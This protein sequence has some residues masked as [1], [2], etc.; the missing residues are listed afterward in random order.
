MHVSIVK[1]QHNSS[2]TAFVFGHLFIHSIYLAT[3][4]YSARLPITGKK[5]R[6]QPT[7]TV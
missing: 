2:V 4:K 6:S 7:L 5:E 3:V 1:R